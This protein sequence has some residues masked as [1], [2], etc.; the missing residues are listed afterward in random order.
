MTQE[1]LEVQTVVTQFY[2]AIEHLVTG[3]GVEPM[4]E[5]WHHSERV[6]IAHPLGDWAYGWDEVAATWKVIASVGRPDIA[7]ST[8]RD[9]RVHLYG[10]VA[11]T[12]CTYVGSKAYQDV[13]LSCT[14]VVHRVDGKWKLVHHHADKSPKLEAG[15][16]KTVEETP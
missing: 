6:T 11:Y 3:R 9:L 15:L 2:D 14:N 8:I 5:V 16:A 13:E 12:T 10:D 1:E 7:G 4:L